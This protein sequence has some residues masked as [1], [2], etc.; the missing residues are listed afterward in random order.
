MYVS[1]PHVC[2]W[3]SFLSIVNRGLYRAMDSSGNQVN[4]LLCY[5]VAK[6]W[7]EERTLVVGEKR[8]EDGLQYRSVRIHPGILVLQKP[9]GSQRQQQSLPPWSSGRSSCECHTYLSFD[10]VAAISTR[11]GAGT[12]R[13]MPSAA[14][15]NG[16]QWF[17]CCVVSECLHCW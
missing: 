13:K 3:R 10:L 8:C 7:I 16:D 15:R 1:G 5:D 4:K 6:C 17:V 14:G 2:G 12:S 9:K 11:A